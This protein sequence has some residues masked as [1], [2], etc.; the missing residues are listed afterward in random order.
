[1]GQSILARKRDIS[2]LLRIFEDSR[3]QSTAPVDV[4]ARPL[5][6]GI[7]QREPGDALARATNN[8]AARL[9]LVEHSLRGRTERLRPPQETGRD[10]DD[11]AR[12]VTTS[13]LAGTLSTSASL[14]RG[15]L[16]RDTAGPAW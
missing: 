9:D 4:E 12:H 11:D 10:S 7:R 15:R 16:R 3:R 6:A 2:R 5:A 8:G 14:K 1:R 13:L